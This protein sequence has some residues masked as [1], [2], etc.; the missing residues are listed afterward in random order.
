GSSLPSVI[1]YCGRSSKQ[2]LNEGD[3]G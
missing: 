1:L 3:G 2:E